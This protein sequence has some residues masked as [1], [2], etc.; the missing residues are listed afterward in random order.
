M[1]GLLDTVI[2]RM[3]LK[4]FGVKRLVGRGQI[5]DI[6][7]DLLIDEGDLLL[8]KFPEMSMEISKALSRNLRH[9][10]YRNNSGMQVINSKRLDIIYTI[11]RSGLIRSFLGLLKYLHNRDGKTTLTH[12]DARNAYEFLVDYFS[13]WRKLVYKGQKSDYNQGKKELDWTLSSS[14]FKYLESLTEATKWRRSLVWIVWNNFMEW[15]QSHKIRGSIN[16]DRH[17]SLDHL[18]MVHSHRSLKYQ[19]LQPD[20][21]DVKQ[22]IPPKICKRRKFFQNN[23]IN[24]NLL[25]ENDKP[26]KYIELG[27]DL[28]KKNT[29]LLISIEDYFHCLQKDLRLNVG[30]ILLE[31]MCADLKHILAKTKNKD[32]SSQNMASLVD[33]CIYICKEKIT[34]ALLGSVLVFQKNLGGSARVDLLVDHGWKFLQ[35]FFSGWKDHSIKAGLQDNL[36]LEFCHKPKNTP[37]W[38]NPLESFYYCL[39]YSQYSHLTSKIFAYLSHQWVDQVTK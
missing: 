13:T 4:F 32:P 23:A 16:T 21:N 27:A 19:N 15:S 11:V 6:I 10:K 2:E 31:D 22:L 35:E 5:Q 36:F 8:G 9:M 37:D 20:M 18:I 7:G 24:N 30:S 29:G 1:E 38:T 14:I 33:N 34:Y 39:I 12:S 17:I 28:V 3:L 26:Q 25:V